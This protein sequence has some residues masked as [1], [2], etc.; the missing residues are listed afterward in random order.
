M[1]YFLAWFAKLLRVVD[2]GHVEVVRELV[3]Q[4]AGDGILPSIG[5]HLPIVRR[6]NEYYSWRLEHL[7]VVVARIADPVDEW[8]ELGGTMNPE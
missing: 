2:L 6:S 3:P 8:V 5:L 4:Q 7:K 1:G